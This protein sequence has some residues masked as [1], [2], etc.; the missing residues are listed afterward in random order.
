MRA[1]AAAASG[2]QKAAFSS[3]RH[4]LPQGGSG[5]ALRLVIWRLCESSAVLLE[6]HQALRSMTLAVSR[7]LRSSY[8]SSPAMRCLGQ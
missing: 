6:R 1:R 4:G 2:L 3:H 8:E 7:L 5:S